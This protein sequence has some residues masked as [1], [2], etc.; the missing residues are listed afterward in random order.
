[1]AYDQELCWDIP[2]PRSSSSETD[3]RDGRAVGCIGV[4]GD[5][6]QHDDAERDNFGCD[7]LIGMTT[8]IA[9][10]LQHAVMSESTIDPLVV[11]DK[12]TGIV[13]R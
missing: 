10:C 6:D 7:E 2:G 12:L 3:G 13:G 11:R 1:M 8:D 5:R 9:L 4:R